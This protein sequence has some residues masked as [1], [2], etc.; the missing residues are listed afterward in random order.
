MSEYLFHYTD[1]ESAR[2]IRETGKIMAH[3]PHGG[4]S[5]SPKGVYFGEIPPTQSKKSIMEYNYD[6]FSGRTE[7]ANKTKRV[8]AFRRKD[9]ERWMKKK[10][11]SSLLRR[12]RNDGHVD[13][14]VRRM[15]ILNIESCM[16]Y[17][18]RF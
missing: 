1:K 16:T 6:G 2:K 7:L 13:G 17:Q 12:V 4:K 8:F 14:S 18:E 9:L 3:D 5:N 15:S 11:G 10:H